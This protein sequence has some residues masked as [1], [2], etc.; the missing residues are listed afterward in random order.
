[1]GSGD[2][3]NGPGVAQSLRGDVFLPFF[4][5]RAEGSGIGLNLARQIVVAHGGS[6]EVVEPTRSGANIRKAGLDFAQGDL[7][8]DKGRLL[9]PA[10]GMFWTG[11]ETCAREY[12]PGHLARVAEQ[13][14]RKPFLWDNYPVNDGA[15]M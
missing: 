15:R 2:D 1:M 9:D 8:L 12:T 7:L 13:M 14:G 4:T 3:D 11:P 6:I 10:I 5:T